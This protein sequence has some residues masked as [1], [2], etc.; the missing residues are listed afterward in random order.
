MGNVQDTR[1]LGPVPE[2]ALETRGPSPV[3][4]RQEV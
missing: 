2:N 3:S 4:N 1:K